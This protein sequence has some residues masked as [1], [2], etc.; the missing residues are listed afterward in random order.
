MASKDDESL[1]MKT[2]K[3]SCRTTGSSSIYQRAFY[4]FRSC[5]LY[6]ER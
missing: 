5:E 3:D 4:D 1:T 2:I 6:R